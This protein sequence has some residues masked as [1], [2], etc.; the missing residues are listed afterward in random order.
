RASTLRRGGGASSPRSEARGGDP[1]ARVPPPWGDAV[2]LLVAPRPSRTVPPPPSS[3]QP[4]CRY[5]GYRPFTVCSV[6]SSPAGVTQRTELDE[7]TQLIVDVLVDAF[8]DL[9]AADAAA[10]PTH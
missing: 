10:F 9:M 4:V 3:S 6:V 7:R 2:V 5:R 1:L 8:A